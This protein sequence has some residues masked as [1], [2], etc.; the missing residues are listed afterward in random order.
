MAAFLGKLTLYPEALASSEQG[1]MSTANQRRRVHLGRH[2]VA[3]HRLGARQVWPR[4]AD[5]PLILSPYFL[6]LIPARYITRLHLR[7]I[8]WNEAD[9]E[10]RLKAVG[11][12]AEVRCCKKDEP[13]HSVTIMATY[14][15]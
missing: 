5:L 4:G 10:G 11:A 3:R 13:L 6:P 7:A 15:V 14:V 9:G 12:C 2:P 8:G 1:T